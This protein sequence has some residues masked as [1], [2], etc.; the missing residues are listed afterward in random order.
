M[1]VYLG[2]KAVGVNSIVEKEVPEERFGVKVSDLLGTVDSDGNYVL[3]TEGFAVDLKGVK[4]APNHSF[5]YFYFGT[6]TQV[7]AKDL[8]SVGVYS[9]M[10]AFADRGAGTTPLMLEFDCLEEINKD[11]A[12]NSFCFGRTNVKGGFK[13][14][15]KVHGKEVFYNAFS[16]TKISPDETF[17]ALEVVSGNGTFYNFKNMRANDVM[18]FSKIQ[19]VTGG[20]ASFSATFICWS[21]VIWKLPSATELSGYVFYSGGA[22]EVHF[23]K[24]HKEMLEACEGYDYKWGATNATLYFDLMLTITVNGV[25]YDREHTID[26]YTSWVDSEGNMVYTNADAEPTVGTVVYS[27]QGTTQ[28]GTVSEAA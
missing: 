23:A 16:S 28:V 9:F 3:P 17:P 27:D 18:V 25:V 15:K 1:T 10:F 26:N 8:V 5:Y 4:S 22:S 19:K 24:A 11:K 6:A 13:R 14:L 21:S 12:F 7:I 20:T 2:D